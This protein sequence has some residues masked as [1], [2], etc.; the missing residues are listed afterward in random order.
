MLGGGGETNVSTL[1]INQPY[2]TVGYKSRRLVGRYISSSIVI[3]TCEI[4]DRCHGA[5]R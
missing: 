5:G 2:I 3:S 1:S 4:I